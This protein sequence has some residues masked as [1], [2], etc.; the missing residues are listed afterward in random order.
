MLRHWVFFCVCASTCCYPTASLLSRAHVPA[1]VL[2]VF[3]ACARILDATFLEVYLHVPVLDATPLDVHLLC[4]CT[5]CYATG[6]LLACAR[7][8]GATPLM[9][10]CMSTSIWCYATGCLLACTHIR[11]RSYATGCFLAC[12]GILDATL[13]GGSFMLAHT[14]CHATGCLLS[15]ASTWCHAIECSFDDAALDAMP[16][17]VYLRVRTYLTHSTGSLLACAHVPDATV[18]DVFLHVQ[19]YL[20][21][22]SLMF[23]CMCPYLMLRH[24]MFTCMCKG[25]WC[26]A[27]GCLLACAHVSDATL[28]D[29]YLHVHTYLMLRAF[30]HF[31]PTSSLKT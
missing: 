11:T 3:F 9:F 6:C 24:W 2:D 10:T 5:W 1:T 23:T 14:W 26:C 16:L 28:L 17:D 27:T 4:T 29:V 12:T 15:F 19:A 21:P 31:V 30:D 8:D 25:T 7:I 22:R 20:M 18:L 13:L